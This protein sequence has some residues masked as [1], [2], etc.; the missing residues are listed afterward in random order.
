MNKYDGGESAEASPADIPFSHN[1][2]VGKLPFRNASRHLHN[3]QAGT[4]RGTCLWV[5]F[6]F[7]AFPENMGHWTEALAPVYSALADGA[8]R[9]RA[10]DGDGRLQAVIFP[11]LRREQV[12]VRG[13]DVQQLPCI[14][15]LP[16]PPAATAVALNWHEPR[17][18]PKLRAPHR[19]LC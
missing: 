6:P 3:I 16:C 14:P 5:D 8:W 13:R 18:A 9:R 4:L 17:P 1:I 19:F 12:E 15:R 2:G 10:P 7:P 11:N